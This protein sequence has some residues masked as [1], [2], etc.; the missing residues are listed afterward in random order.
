MRTIS[1]IIL[2]IWGWKVSMAVEKTQRCILIVAPHTS[3]FDFVIG[4]IALSALGLRSR[5]MIKKEAF[6]FP[7]NLVLLPLGGIPVDRNH[8]NSVAKHMVELI[9]NSDEICL[10]ITPEGTRRKVRQW[11]KGYYFLAQAADVPIYLGYVD[12][13]TRI[14][15]IG[16][17][18][19]PSGD[20]EKDFGTIASF[21]K[22]KK[23]RHP[24]RFSLGPGYEVE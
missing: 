12:Y 5:F 16:H 2:K 20:Y 7:L 15:H 19:E 10:V 23:G 1:K 22:G 6:R 8:G 14:C 18:L 13:S 24:E 17:I 3:Y 11:K 4:K 21:Y 9:R